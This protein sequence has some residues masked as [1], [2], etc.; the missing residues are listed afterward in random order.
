[1]TSSTCTSF[2]TSSTPPPPGRRKKRDE[3][4]TRTRTTR[5]TS[6]GPSPKIEREEE[7]E[8]ENSKRVVVITGGNTG[9]GFVA[10]REIAAMRD[11][12]HVVA[13][14]RSIERG[15]EAFKEEIMGGKGGDRAKVDVM[16]CD[17][18]SFGSVQ[19][20]AE[21]FT[22]KY[23]RL[24]VLMN[25]AGIMALPERMESEDGNELQMQTN[26]LSH[27]M[28]TAKLMPLML[29]TERRH[30]ERRP[31]VVNV[32]SIA[33]E[34]GFI[35]NAN[36][37]SEGP[38]G[39]PGWGWITYGRTKMANVL[40]TY[41]LQRKLKQRGSKIQAFCVHPGVV[42]TELQRNLPIDWYANLRDIGRLID[43]KEGAR[44]QIYVATSADLENDD[45]GKYFSELSGEGKPG[46]HAF[47]PSNAFSLDEENWAR[48]W[49]ESERLT[50]I[51]FDDVLFSHHHRTHPKDEQREGETVSNAAAA[52]VVFD[53]SS[54][55][56][57]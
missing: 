47:R 9:L 38:F 19:A 49:K 18:A 54:I 42:D 8:L 33:H 40:F 1:M 12:Y 17:L 32:A 22:K 41:E 45:G 11:E 31:R 4:R 51:D 27:F 16:E 26:H 14:C 13:A 36:M 34:W 55:R 6:V 10:A 50:G 39:Y 5:R 30:P 46:E 53:D 48:V 29:A 15:R 20:F 43:P 28:L 25:N 52:G 7:D 57:R 35:D 21:Q 23:G 24:D 2:L 37:N 3:R 44:G 56:T